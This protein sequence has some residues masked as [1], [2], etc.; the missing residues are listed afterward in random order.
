M[1]PRTIVPANFGRIRRN[2]VNRLFDN[3]TTFGGKLM[4]ET[5]R[6]PA[7]NVIENETTLYV[8]AELPGVTL[9][10]IEVTL[11]GTELIIKGQR[12]INIPEKAHVVR[13]ERGN[14]TFER[15]IEL[16]FDVVADKVEAKI[17]N[18]ILVIVLPKSENSRTQT[19]K[20]KG[21]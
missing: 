3:L 14:L 8:E 7:L 15:T 20:V 1:T 21:A 19:I 12:N 16:P 18:G 2:D 5:Q 13:Q 10:E 9:E 6:F 17:T 11:I 4:T